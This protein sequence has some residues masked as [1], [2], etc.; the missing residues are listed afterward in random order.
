[1][2]H[3]QILFGLNRIRKIAYL[4]NEREL[5][6]INLKVLRR[7]WVSTPQAEGAPIFTLMITSIRV[8]VH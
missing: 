6:L 4:C 8:P 2:Y 1:M 3:W 5:R 7:S